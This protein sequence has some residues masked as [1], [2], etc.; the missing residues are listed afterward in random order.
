MELYSALILLS[1]ILATRMLL[2]IRKVQDAKAISVISTLIFNPVRKEPADWDHEEGQKSHPT[3][4]E[5]W[6][7]SALTH[8]TL[9]WCAKDVEAAP[10]G[11]A[12]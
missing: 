3:D 7:K 1:P 4:S 9:E 11:K 8:K 12:N 6:A 5:V 2:L 10:G